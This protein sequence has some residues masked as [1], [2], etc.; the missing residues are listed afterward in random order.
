[1]DREALGEIDVFLSFRADTQRIS[2]TVCS[3]HLN[4]ENSALC[5]EIKQGECV[6]VWKTGEHRARLEGSR[7][8]A[9]SL[10]LPARV[11]PW[12]HQSQ[13][14][15]PQFPWV[16]AVLAKMTVIRTLGLWGAHPGGP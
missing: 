3:G 2:F 12:W 5:L 9:F 7:E 8:L 6:W 1:M 15:H 16:E 10:L 11:R 14:S 13:L 4:C